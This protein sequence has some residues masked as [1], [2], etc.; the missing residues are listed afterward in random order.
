MKLKPAAAIILDEHRRSDVD[1][2][3]KACLDS[4]GVAQ[5]LGTVHFNDRSNGGNDKVGVDDVIPL[6]SSDPAVY[7]KD[8]KRNVRDEMCR[9]WCVDRFRDLADALERAHD[10]AAKENVQLELLRK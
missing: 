2:I 5:Q 8:A 4:L 10:A 9:D 6:L 7:C 3:N 1:G